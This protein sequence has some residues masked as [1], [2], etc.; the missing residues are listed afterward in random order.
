MRIIS[1]IL[2]FFVLMIQTIYAQVEEVNPPDFIKTIN[3]KSD[4]NES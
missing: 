4:T 1:Y 3:F 2:Y